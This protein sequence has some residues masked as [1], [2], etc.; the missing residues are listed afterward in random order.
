MKMQPNR[1]FFG[2]SNFNEVFQRHG[3]QTRKW[4][5]RFSAVQ[6]MICDFWRAISAILGKNSKKFF[7]SLG[8]EDAKCKVFKKFKKL[9]DRKFAHICASQCDQ[10]VMFYTL[11]DCTTE[12]A[13]KGESTIIYY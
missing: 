8:M 6:I 12:E 7:R 9:Q 13:N 11:T 3:F 4:E 1:R 2:Y 5:N 10:V